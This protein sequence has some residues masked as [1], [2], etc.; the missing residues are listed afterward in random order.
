MRGQDGQ[1]CVH[2]RQCLGAT[3]NVNHDND[4]PSRPFTFVRGHRGDLG[5][6]RQ[7]AP[8]KN[9]TTTRRTYQF[10]RSSN[11]GVK[12]NDW[13]QDVSREDEKSVRIRLP[14]AVVEEHTRL[15]EENRG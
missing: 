10:V 8:C 5:T 3:S 1:A 11:F 9:E 2:A 4:L 15:E 12:S 14:S 7:S 6:Y 13:N